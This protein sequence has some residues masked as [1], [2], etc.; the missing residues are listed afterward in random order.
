MYVTTSHMHRS[1]GPQKLSSQFYRLF[2][3]NTYCNYCNYSY[4]I[5][6]I[7]TL[8]KD[9]LFNNNFM[10]LYRFKVLDYFYIHAVF[11]LVMDL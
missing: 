10:T 5:T 6:L 2:F 1:K 11:D 9:T 3:I 4:V 8:L 7:Q